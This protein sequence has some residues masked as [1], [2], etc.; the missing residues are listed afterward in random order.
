M[1]NLDHDSNLAKIALQ[2]AHVQR[3][4]AF[5]ATL[6]A[7][8]TEQ[9]GGRPLKIERDGDPAAVLADVGVPQRRL[10]PPVLQLPPPDV[11]VRTE[12][13]TKVPA[14]APAPAPVVAPPRITLPMAAPAPIT[15]VDA[16]VAIAAARRSVIQQLN[17]Q[18]SRR[19][20]LPAL[21]G[22]AGQAPRRPGATIAAARR[23][24]ISQLTQQ[25]SQR[26][27]LLPPCH[28]APGIPADASL[29]PPAVP[30]ITPSVTTSTNTAAAVPSIGMVNAHHMYMVPAGC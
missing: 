29:L 20:V 6:G 10:S 23:L 11:V 7:P 1:A 21:A 8:P 4:K 16:V 27:R 22:Q 24:V 3:L 2:R 26:L 17:Q 18:Q 19:L 5:R 13:R 25:W 12:P 30:T 9:P 15:T 14:P 28:V